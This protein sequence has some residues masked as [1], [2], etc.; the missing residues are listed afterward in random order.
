[1]KEQYLLNKQDFKFLCDLFE[2]NLEKLDMSVSSSFYNFLL[3]FHENEAV[4]ENKKYLQVEEIAHCIE[5]NFEPMPKVNLLSAGLWRFLNNISSSDSKYQNLQEVYRYFK[6]KD[7][8]LLDKYLA[9]YTTDEYNY[10]HTSFLPTYLNVISSSQFSSKNNP[11]ELSPNIDPTLY[12]KLL[13]SHS[14]DNKQYLLQKS[15]NIY[16]F[17]LDN[18]QKFNLHEAIDNFAHL[19]I[20]HKS[21]SKTCFKKF[22]ATG[23]K[24]K[25]LEPEYFQKIC[26]DYIEVNQKFSLK[27]TSSYQEQSGIFKLWKF[28]FNHLSTMRDNFNISHMRDAFDIMHNVAVVKLADFP[29]VINLTQEKESG[30]L[31]INLLVKESPKGLQL[32]EDFKIYMDTIYEKGVRGQFV[33]TDEALNLWQTIQLTRNLEKD[34]R[35]EKKAVGKKNKI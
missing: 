29:D 34:L 28:D 26:D 14:K 19:C 5:R 22:F 1:M 18:P 27:N 31:Q 32:L 25:Q 21:I 17:I 13:K 35:Q 12:M 7:I 3:C 9:Q 2:K 16:E 8:D 23:E 4:F 15:L 33:D 24:L 11:P 20:I 6:S 30:I 10:Y